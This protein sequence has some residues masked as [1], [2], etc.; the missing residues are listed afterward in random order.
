MTEGED[1]AEEFMRRHKERERMCEIRGDFIILDP[2]DIAY[3][4]ELDDC[5]THQKIIRWVLH[6][7]RKSW[8]SRDMLQIFVGMACNYHGLE[9]E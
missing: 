6:L 1:D 2:D 4:I 5:D 3:E 8:F 7:S 9:S